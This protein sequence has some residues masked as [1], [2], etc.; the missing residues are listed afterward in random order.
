MSNTREHVGAMQNKLYMNIIINDLEGVCSIHSMKTHHCYE[1]F[2]VRKE[3]GDSGEGGRQEGGKGG[4]DGGGV[5][6]EGG[7]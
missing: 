1:M 4:M 6:R 5:G 3:G 2:M 7:R